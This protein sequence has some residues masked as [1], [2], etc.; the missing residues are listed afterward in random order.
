[1]ATPFDRDPDAEPLMLTL[2]DALAAANAVQQRDAE[3]LAMVLAGVPQGVAVFDSQQRLAVWNQRLITLFGLTPG[4][5][6]PGM[7]SSDYAALPRPVRQLRRRDDD[8][9][10]IALDWQGFV[11]EPGRYEEILTDGRTIEVAVIRH[12]SGSLIK[13]YA[14]VTDSIDA[15]NELTLRGAQL[16]QRIRELESL[17]T[18]LEESRNR[19]IRADQ[20]KSRFLAMM[21]HD[22]RTPMNA[23][24][25]LLDLVSHGHLD[26]EQRRHIDLV[27][28][29]GE[30]ML[31]L[32]G[33][34]LAVARSDGW[35]MELESGLIWV[36]DFAGRTVDSWRQLA[37]T[38]S[39]AME[40]TIAPNVPNQVWMDAT[41]LR[42]LLDNLISN[43]IKFT[44]QGRIDVT[45]DRLADANGAPQLCIAVRD[46][47]R[48]IAH[49]DQQKL[50][51]DLHR[52]HDPLTGPV[53]GNG[54]GLAICQ[55]IAHA[56]GGAISVE[57]DIGQGSLFRLVLPLSDQHKSDQQLPGQHKDAGVPAPMA[58]DAAPTGPLNLHLLVAEDIETNRFVMGALLDRLGCTSQMVPDGQ[59]AIDALAAGDFDAILMDISMPGMDGIA[60]TQAIRKLP[61]PAASLPIIAVTAFATDRERAA[62]LAAGMNAVL[63]KPVRLDGLAR[64]LALLARSNSGPIQESRSEA[65]AALDRLDSAPIPDFAAV[66]L[67][68]GNMFRQQLFSLPDSARQRL[69]A[70]IIADLQ[71]WTAAFSG[72]WQQGDSDGMARA[73]HAL[74]GV[75]AS[76]GIVKLAEQ[77]G[78]MRTAPRL[79][80][81]RRGR[82][83][84]TILAASLEEIS[85]IASQPDR[86]SA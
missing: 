8:G 1:M 81:D 85:R 77:L 61:A 4:H 32:L 16:A 68:D 71:H 43:A 19:A 23:M 28:S 63:V 59:A 47:G 69:A 44:A 58:G 17:S 57:S 40:L 9:K 6:Y 31:F 82:D 5:L 70:S 37:R 66:P 34:I 26:D 39:L 53:E 76:F 74:K 72:A 79:A 38:R 41:R 11:A 35:Q 20:A 7:A 84:D 56:M 46:T 86:R 18:S 65:E 21:S 15:H 10:S 73:H 3:F 50:F 51:A 80:D 60:A 62:F 45:I 14:D 75:C 36:R 29:S 42:Q 30:Q 54:L 78:M 49:G 12:D 2:A 24:L 67:I 27:R 22:I 13:T 48:G 55:R 83:L 33:D 52:V 25:A 64:E